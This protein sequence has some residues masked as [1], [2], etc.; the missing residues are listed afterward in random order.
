MNYEDLFKETA[1]VRIKKG[2]GRT[3]KAGGAWI[4]DNEID[5]ISGDF[6]NGDLVTVEDFDGY[7]LGHGFINTSSNF[8]R[9]MIK[10]QFILCGC[11][12]GITCIYTRRCGL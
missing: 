5:A 2:T 11:I 3:L 9:V 7:P 10:V 8:P 12:G 6:E 1:C 4:Y